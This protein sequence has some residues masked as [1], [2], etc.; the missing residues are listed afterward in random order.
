[1]AY[2]LSF[3]VLFLLTLFQCA[4]PQDCQSQQFGRTL[5]EGATGASVVEATISKITESGIFSNDFGFLR[6]MASFETDNGATAT[7]GGGGIWRVSATVLNLINSFISVPL[8]PL[9]D[10]EDN[11]EKKFCFRWSNT[12]GNSLQR[13]DTPLYSALAVMMAVIIA[14]DEKFPKYI[15]S[16]A[17]L[18]RGRFNPLGN[19]DDFISHANFLE[20]QGNKINFFMLIMMII[21]FQLKTVKSEELI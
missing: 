17:Q 19:I 20:I 10:I 2:V 11:I 13:L 3:K 1:M 4:K 21:F 12:V 8:S 9:P 18:W 6:R 5:E 14:S 16:Q 15:P 7:P